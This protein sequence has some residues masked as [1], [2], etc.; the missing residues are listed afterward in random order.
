MLLYIFFTGNSILFVV[1]MS[2]IIKSYPS[3]IFLKVDF[4]LEKNF[5]WTLGIAGL[6]YNLGAWVDKF[7]FWYHPATGGNVI[8]K[9]NA[10][11]VYDMPIFLAYFSILPGMAIFFF[12]LEADFA[13]KYDLYYDA[14]RSGGTL[15]L[16]KQYR[17]DMT[18]IIRQAIREI[19]IIQGI[20]DVILFLVAP[21]LFDWLHI[22]VIYLGLFYIL[23][24]GAMLQLAFMS[25]LAILY[26]LDRKK[27]AMWLSI[28]F[29]VLNG[30]M[31]LES[32]N[33]GTAMYGYGYTG[34]LLIVFVLAIIAIREEMK[35][36]NYE[37]FM[38]Q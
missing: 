32:I 33:M 30:V 15:D 27:P 26:Y 11:V 34:S 14:V 17:D 19:L 38:L 22:S 4:F 21:T 25:I 6:A 18:T 35:R 7:I 31:T 24:I 36:L 16:I 37:T 13:E 5:Y 28:A 3:T 9:L 12:R 29:F 20:M 10:S 23:T 2:L 8:G 1:L